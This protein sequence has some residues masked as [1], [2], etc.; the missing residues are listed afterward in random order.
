MREALAVTFLLSLSCILASGSYDAG[1][2]P[3]SGV[4]DTYTA[5]VIYKRNH[6]SSVAAK[7]AVQGQFCSRFGISPCKAVAGDAT[8]VHIKRDFDIHLPAANVTDVLVWLQQYRYSRVNAAGYDLDVMLY[9]DSGCPELDTTF[10]VHVGHKSPFNTNQ[11]PAGLGLE[12]STKSEYT[13]VKSWEHTAGAQA[14]DDSE[15]TACSSDATCYEPYAFNTTCTGDSLVGSMHF[16]FY[17]VSNNPS[18]VTAANAFIN[19]TTTQ[20][21]LAEDVCA[22]NS[23][24]EQPH[25]ASC[26]LSGPGGSGPIGQPASN[27]TKVGGSFAYPDYSL[28][29]VR[30]DFLKVLSYTMVMKN[31]AYNGIGEVDFL[32]HPNC[33]CNY[34]DHVFW[35]LHAT[36]YIPANRQGCAE[37]AGWEETT[38]PSVDPWSVRA[39]GNAAVEGCGLTD[40]QA[41]FEQWALHMFYDAS[42]GSAA[43]AQASFVKGLQATAAAAKAQIEVG[44]ANAKAYLDERS[45]ALTSEQVVTFGA[46]AFD[47]VAPWVMVHRPP[48]VDIR[49][50]PLSSKGDTCRYTDYVSRAMYGGQHWEIN[51][52]PVSQAGFAPITAP[53]APLGA[54]SALQNG[55]CLYPPSGYVLYMAAV[56]DNGYQMYSAGLDSYASGLTQAF[57]T[58]FPNASSCSSGATSGAPIE[59]SYSV[60]CSMGSTLEPFTDDAD[61]MMLS[62]TAVYV[63]PAELAAVMSWA[64][65]NHIA[66]KVYYDVDLRL[67][68]LTGC[69][70]QDYAQSALKTGPDWRINV[71]A[72][73]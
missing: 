56:N 31:R 29:V 9:P 17:Y 39:P 1:C 73:A 3:K 7:E 5:A 42:N 51:E 46:A 63:P 52:Y 43:S 71:A 44:A 62:Y 41:S 21:G 35:G 65:D 34:A 4:W 64:M 48:A 66:A 16:H 19:A 22:D 59:P 49:L 67:V 33:G 57:A 38:A 13:A 53:A 68:P 27:D 60:L 32:V 54:S 47:V 28:Y 55:G 69:P 20:F 36:T 37:E 24:H 30:A 25:N 58:A 45:V 6:P 18:S 72:L 23:G 2:V 10:A 50:V 8:S 61:P 12:D 40:S 15:F 11:L 70:M 26:W 14:E